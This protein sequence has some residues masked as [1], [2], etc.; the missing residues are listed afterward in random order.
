MESREG[1]Q[2]PIPWRQEVYSI[3]RFRRFAEVS[4]ESP[5]GEEPAPSRHSFSKFCDA[6]SVAWF[7]ESWSSRVR[8]ESSALRDPGR[9]GG[10]TTITARVPGYGRIIRSQVP[11]RQYFSAANPSGIMGT[12]SLRESAAAPSFA[13]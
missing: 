1:F 4:P 6:S 7:K 5:R 9:T 3:R 11:K 10:A 13:S 8:F 2:N 12:P